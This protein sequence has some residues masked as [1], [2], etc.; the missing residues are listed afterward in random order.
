VFPLRYC[1]YVVTVAGD[2][3]PWGRSRHSAGYLTHAV[4]ELVMVWRSGR[5][6]T[7]KVRWRCAASTY[8]FRLLDEPDSPICP[9][10]TVERHPR[11]R[12]KS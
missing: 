7:A 9:L 11:E 5:L 3:L 12:S 1:G 8:T 10:C 4:D 2:T 6:V